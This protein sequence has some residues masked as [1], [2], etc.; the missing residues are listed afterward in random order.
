MSCFEFGFA[1]YR[2]H[3]LSMPAVCGQC[4]IVFLENHR[5]LDRFP[6]RMGKPEVSTGTNAQELLNE[7][8]AWAGCMR[9]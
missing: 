8:E 5:G 3:L 1:C 2:K 4:R 6:M 7:L 9:T